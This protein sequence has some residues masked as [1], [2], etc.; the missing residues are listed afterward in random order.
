VPAAIEGVATRSTIEGVIPSSGSLYTINGIV[1]NGDGRFLSGSAAVLL[2]MEG[3]R[4][5]RLVPRSAIM[6]DGDLTGVLV[7]TPNGPIVRWVRLGNDVGDFT[8][9]ISGLDAGITVLVPSAR[10]A[11]N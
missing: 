4:T 9:V 5:A 3:Q 8:E 6:R 2:L 7:K 11:G 1:P 10:V